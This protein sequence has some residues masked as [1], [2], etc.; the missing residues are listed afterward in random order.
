M[1]ILATASIARRK[2][3]RKCKR[4]VVFK[5]SN[6]DE[7]RF[8]NESIYEFLLRISYLKASVFYKNGVDVVGAD[9]VLMVDDRIIG[10]PKNKEDAG[11]ILKLLSGRKHLCLTG[12]AVLKNNSWIGFIER[13]VVKV[14]NLSDDLIEQYLNTD[15]WMGRA[16]GYAIQGR[17]K[18]FMRVVEGDITTV[19]GLPMKRLC[20]II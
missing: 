10:K 3:L 4:N 15:E 17:A 12:V 16:G 1:L 13:A 9:T 5:I 18:E 2:L 20:R 7:K 6:V 19:I 11:E 14:D 8:D